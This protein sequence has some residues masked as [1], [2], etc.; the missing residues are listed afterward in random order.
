MTL[1]MAR[2]VRLSAAATMLLA[3]TLG[4]VAAAGPAQAAASCT[5]NYRLARIFS[6][7]PFSNPTY[8]PDGHGGLIPTGAPTIGY[9]F[10]GTFDMTN[11]GDALQPWTAAWVT[12]AA[13][14]LTG[15]GIYNARLTGLMLTDD[16]TQ[17][18]VASP[19]QYNNSIPPGG[20][21]SFGFEAKV[22]SPYVDTSHLI[23]S[24]SLSGR[25][26]TIV[27]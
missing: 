4:G 16:D 23:S 20:T 13:T 14:F 2:K 18:Q 17:W 3:S 1:S 10:L 24:F 8:V 7:D 5:V 19:L 27:S 11:L 26:C 15:S 22:L 12:P 25:A 21:M 9:S 6:I